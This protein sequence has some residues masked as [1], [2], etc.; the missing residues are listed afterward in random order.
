MILVLLA[1][2]EYYFFLPGPIT[3]PRYQIPALPVLCI[4][5]GAGCLR[6]FRRFRREKA[7]ISAPSDLN[8]PETDLSYDS[9][10]INPKNQED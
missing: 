10:G 6:L 4:L 7:P 8:F 3:V 9:K 1:C 2:A 5:G